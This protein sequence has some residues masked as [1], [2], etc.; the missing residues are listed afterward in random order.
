MRE[1]GM[2]VIFLSTDGDNHTYDTDKRHSNV[3]K[4]TA[5]FSGNFLS[6]IVRLLSRRGASSIGRSPIC[7]SAEEYATTNT[8]AWRSAAARACGRVGRWR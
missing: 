2:K 3:F 7:C 5:E 8:P 1:L 4:Q 6:K